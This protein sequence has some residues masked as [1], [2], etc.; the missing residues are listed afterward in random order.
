MKF[1]YLKIG[2][3]F[4][5]F[6]LS[7]TAWAQ[8]KTITGKVTS[9]EGS[10]LPGVSV[11][12]KGNSVG[13]QTN[14]EGVYTID[15]A[16]GDVINFSSVGYATQSVKVENSA[17]INVTLN[18]SA[19]KLGEVVV[20]GYGTQNRRDVTS[21]IGK[22]DNQVLTTAPRAN[23]GTA[24]QGSVA[25]VQVINSSGTPGSSPYI[26]LRG[27]A[28]INNPGAPLVVVDGII[29]SF[30]DI[31]PEDIASIDLLRDAA[32]TAIYGARANNGVILITTKKGKAGKAEIS[33]KFTDGH[34]QQRAG[35]NYLDAKDY[36]YYNRLGNLNSGRTLAQ[37]NG[38][39]GYGLLTDPADLASFDIRAYSGNE[40]LL[41]QGW[42]TLSDPYG[43]SVTNPSGAIIFKDHGGE[44]K[45][46]LFRNTQT[47]DHYINL[48]A[49]NDKS[50]VFGSFDYYNEGGVI[51]GSNYNRYTGDVNYSYKVRPDLEVT[52]GGTFSTSNQLG[53]PNSEINT[54]YRTQALWPT[55]N[56]WLDSAKTLPNP[57][58]G[59]S[60][61]NP[62]Y[63]LSKIQRSNV[64][65]RITANTSVKYDITPDLY[66]RGTASIYYYENLQQYHQ[67]ATQTYAQYFSN[68]QTFSTSRPAY[69]YFNNL[70]QQQY[71]A[72]INYSKTFLSKNHLNAMLG[73]EFF[74]QKNFIMQVYGTNSPTDLITTV[75]ASTTF[76][77]GSNYSTK[78]QNSIVS[79]FGRINY[80]YDNR[81]LVTLVGRQDGVSNLATQQRWGFFPGM[82]AGW[83]MQNEK[84]YK[85]SSLHEVLSTFKPRISYG[86]NGNIAGVG[87]YDVQGVFGSRGNYN[88]I[89]GYLNTSPVNSGLQ[90]EKSTT[91]DVGADFGF[92]R[93]RITLLFDYYDRKTSNL[94]TSLAL[95]SY[96]GYSSVTTN[97]GTFQNKGYEFTL[98]ANILRLPSGFTWNVSANISYDR[99]KVLKLPFNGNANNRQ[100]GLQIWNPKTNQLE[101]VGGIQEG[102]PLGNIY[103]YKQVSIF[104]DEA[105]VEAIAGNRV[106]KIANITGPNLPAGPGSDG[107]HIS[108]GDVNW[109]DV[110]KNDTIDARDQVYIGNIYPKYT[111]GFS[112]DLSYHN[113]SIF[114]RFDYSLGYTIYDDQ[115]ARTLGN[116][117]GTFN[118]TTLQKDSWSP[119]NEIT[120]IPKVYYADQVQGAGKQNYT[121]GNN[122]SAVL[123]G[124]NS[125]MYEKGNY[126]ACREISLSYD[127]TKAMLSKTRFLTHARVFVSANNLFYV[128]KFRG[129]SPEPPLNSNG[130]IYGIYQGTYPTPKTFVFGAQVSF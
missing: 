63:L 99:N 111:G 92:F 3:F 67:D 68:P 83:N 43:A 57:G 122:A 108:P 69:D 127:F 40:N 78:T 112:T 77:A 80:D 2:I 35:F 105:D 73:T 8:T 36:I 30:N 46:L 107:G 81:Y 65:N 93:N 25:G 97:S 22:V 55:M 89:G 34:N 53:T 26:L 64:T 4:T 16:R 76:A 70:F 87:P 31:A 113:F 24:L 19:D 54:I 82:S 115:L 41:S 86:Q 96:V 6:L 102:Q 123:N 29:R 48:V 37:V 94:L 90:W 88:N 12:L 60:D 109:L 116:Y 21:S 120:N 119:T 50:K 23:V 104:K 128:T 114:A 72:T 33:Y 98:N 18:V 47:Q 84:F 51:V 75:N 1:S 52:T 124:N 130:V 118:Y 101:W 44:I 95:P 91:T 56:P 32:A 103:A 39:R 61:G 100:G 74:G 42:D 49:G 10:P 129:L 38:T 117:Q 106:D 7:A 110:D 20:V 58:N 5:C 79:G 45:D 9:S 62:L 27:G 11:I 28:S 121:R 126:V 125:S 14:A 15:A 17:I 66:V 13:T 85:N 71:D 59:G